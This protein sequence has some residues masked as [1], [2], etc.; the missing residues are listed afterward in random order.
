MKIMSSKFNRTYVS[1]VP[2]LCYDGWGLTLPST[3]Y[4]ELIVSKPFSQL[5]ASVRAFVKS[6]DAAKKTPTR[7]K[8]EALRKK[9]AAQAKTTPVEEEEQEEEVNGDG[10]EDELEEDDDD[11]DNEEEED[12]EDDDDG[13]LFDDEDNAMFQSLST[14][15]PDSQE[16]VI[17]DSV[18]DDDKEAGTAKK[19]IKITEQKAMM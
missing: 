11:D 14:T 1:Q 16:Y 9:K 10:D 5:V 12:E 19:R 2:E 13:T 18:I 6:R 4:Q 7:V 3:L 17:Q 15:T 8:L